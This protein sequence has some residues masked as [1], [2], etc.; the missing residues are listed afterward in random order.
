MRPVRSAVSMSNGAASGA[1][2]SAERLPAAL[3][4][5][6]PSSNA[7]P[8]GAPLPP[9]TRSAPSSANSRRA[10]ARS[11]AESASRHAALSSVAS[12]RGG[13]PASARVRGAMRAASAG[14]SVGTAALAIVF[15]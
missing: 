12:T 2:S 5:A 9:N 11:S 1:R 10:I 7:W 4:R 14:A 15:R 8:P 13:V 3:F 6:A